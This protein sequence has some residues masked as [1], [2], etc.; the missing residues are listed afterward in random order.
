[1]DEEWLDRFRR[2]ENRSISMMMLSLPVIQTVF[3]DVTVTFGVAL[4]GGL[5]LAIFF[6]LRLLAEKILD[7]T[8]RKKAALLAAALVASLVVLSLSLFLAL[9]LT[10]VNA[11]ALL[12][13]V[14]LVLLSI[15]LELFWPKRGGR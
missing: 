5:E 14:A 10:P 2:I 6:G 15:L 8:S 3:D 4:G 1:M 9:Q 7:S 12:G 13:G 11:P